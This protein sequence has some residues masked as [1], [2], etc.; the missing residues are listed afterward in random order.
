MSNFS[1]T[2][3]VIQCADCGAEILA[4]HNRTK[5]C[6][7][8]A[9]QREKEGAARRKA[10]QRK[11][12]QAERPEGPEDREVHYCDSPENV[13]KCLNCTKPKCTNCLHHGTN[14]TK[15]SRPCVLSDEVR[16]N[17]AAL[18]R[19]GVKQNVIAKQFG[20]SEPTVSRW[21]S[22]LRYEGAI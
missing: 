16:E 13:Q 3:R 8:C 6:T 14:T 15:K 9:K 19:K 7:A 12:L 18:V 4:T 5:Y 21:V 2:P 1:W 11:K 20:V 17:V 10:K 22:G